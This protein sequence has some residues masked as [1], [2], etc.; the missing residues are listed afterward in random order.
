MTASQ[1]TFAMIA[2]AMAA[3]R[4]SPFTIVVHAI[5][6]NDKWDTVT[7]HHRPRRRAEKIDRAVDECVRGSCALLLFDVIAT[8]Y[9]RSSV[10]VTTTLLFENWTEVLGSERLTGA[11]LDR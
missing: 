3:L 5:S 11:T 2:A 1:T 8:A 6:A 10:M 4:W 7:W 9:E